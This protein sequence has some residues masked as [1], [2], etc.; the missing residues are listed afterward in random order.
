MHWGSH[1]SPENRFK[2]LHYYLVLRA[3]TFPLQHPC[4]ETI[5]GSVAHAR[6]VIGIIRKEQVEGVSGMPMLFQWSVL[7]EENLHGQVDFDELCMSSYESVVFF[8][9][10]GTQ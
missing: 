9:F 1:N 3:L 8:Q 4:A 6:L 7:E 10:W 5:A 2:C